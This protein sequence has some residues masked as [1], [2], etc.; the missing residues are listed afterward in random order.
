MY[1]NELRGSELVKNDRIAVLRILNHTVY[2]YPLQMNVQYDQT[3]DKLAT[4]SLAFLVTKHLLTLPGLV[5][6]SQLESL[7][8]PNAA[9]S[10]ASA[11]QM[12][13]IEKI[14]TVVSA[15]TTAITVGED[16]K[17]Y[18]AS[19]HKNS[20]LH[21]NVAQILALLDEGD[22]ITSNLKALHASITENLEASDGQ[23][24][25]FIA[26][27]FGPTKEKVEAWFNVLLALV[28]KSAFETDSSTLSQFRRHLGTIKDFM[29]SLQSLMWAIK[30]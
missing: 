1:N 3:M 27:T 4:F 13:M 24:S 22:A 10:T 15:C 20:L 16:S 12:A 17:F 6:T 29:D 21:K 2:G 8:D 7:Y 5:S 14:R 25:P 18:Q 9:T 30:G 19:S 11:A 23:V 28:D 26:Q